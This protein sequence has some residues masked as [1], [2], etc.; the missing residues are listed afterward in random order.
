MPTPLQPWLDADCPDPDEPLRRTRRSGDAGFTLIEVLVV[1]LIMVILM[2]L[3]IGKLSGSKRSTYAKSA[4]AAALTYGDA[5]D[6]YMADH[7]QRVPKPNTSAWPALRW[8]P[9]DQMLAGPAGGAKPYLRTIPEHVES[10]LVS[11][12]SPSPNAQAHIDYQ[13]R[14]NGQYVLRVTVHGRPSATC[15][16]T[17]A[18]APNMKRCT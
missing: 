11:F 4:I 12:E 2:G 10:G 6:A 1:M 15:V 13:A 14:A 8:G 3:V 9:V 5:V 7:G 17:N 16:V 18:P